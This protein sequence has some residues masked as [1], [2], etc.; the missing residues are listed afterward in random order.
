MG[1]VGLIIFIFFIPYA[2]I[3]WSSL[4]GKKGKLQRKIAVGVF[5]AVIL[6]SI[7][8]NFSISRAYELSFF[9]NGFESIVAVIIAAVLLL[10]IVIINVFVS[11]IF[12]DA[13]KSIHNPKAVWVVGAVLCSTILFFTIWVYPLGEKTSY[14][15][16]VEDALD[17]AEERQDDEEI[18][19]VFMSSEKQCFRTRTSSSNCNT[20]NYQN[21]FFLKNNL[22]EQ[23]QVQVQIR[24][25]DSKQQ[26]L[27]V[28]ES[29]VMTLEAGEL[30]LLETEE[31]SDLSS[32][33]SRSSFETEYRT[34]SYEYKYRYK[35]AK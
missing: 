19:V 1:T 3:L 10:V 17:A 21:S 26:E 11:R 16:K 20:A 32:I 29:D 30:K 34:Q 23:K 18:T 33:W 7:I 6:A 8:V 4:S 27:K 5:I 24:A 2:W 28:V 12:K 35:D 25:L 22:D 14:V 15:L 9:Q 13:P 31:S